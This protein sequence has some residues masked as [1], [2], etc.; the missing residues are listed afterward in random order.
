MR[1]PS[2]YIIFG[3]DFV[4]AAKNKNNLRVNGN[5]MLHQRTMS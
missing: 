2:A 3:A 5:S 1:R 4:R